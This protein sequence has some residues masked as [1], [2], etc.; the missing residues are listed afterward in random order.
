MKGLQITTPCNPIL[1]VLVGAK[2]N[3]GRYGGIS[4]LLSPSQKELNDDLN[5]KLDCNKNRFQQNAAGQPQVIYNYDPIRSIQVAS[6]A[7]SCATGQPA[8]QALTGTYTINRPKELGTIITAQEWT[9]FCCG[10]DDYFKSA[11]PNI[12]FDSKVNAKLANLEVAGVIKRNIGQRID[13]DLLNPIELDVIAAINTGSGLNPNTLSA[14]AQNVNLINAQ[15][16]VTENLN[17]IAQQIQAKMNLCEGKWILLTG[18][19]SKVQQ[20]MNRCNISC[21]NTSQGLDA[22]AIVKQTSSYFDWYRSTAIDALLGQDVAFLIAPNSATGHFMGNFDY[23]NKEKWGK[24]SYGNLRVEGSYCDDAAC[25]SQAAFTPIEFGV[26]VRELDCDNGYV[27]PAMNVA[28]DVQYGI[29][30]KPTGFYYATGP[31]INYTGI[32]KLQFV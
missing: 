25:I 11:Y 6:N 19:G 29:F 16:Q 3:Y 15:G 12:A 5:P 21:C 23:M 7:I 14:A 18:T 24:T 17:I 20:Y 22:N 1:S 4:A 8:P 2:K 10:A 30:T 13:A 9:K 26:R 32:V 31:Y 27:H 28:L